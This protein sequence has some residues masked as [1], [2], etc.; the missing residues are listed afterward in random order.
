MVWS[1]PHERWKFAHRTQLW[2][3]GSPIFSIKVFCNKWLNSWLHQSQWTTL[4]KRNN[5]WDGESFFYSNKFEWKIIA[6]EIERVAFPAS[7]SG[8]LSTFSSGIGAFL[9]FEDYIAETVQFRT[10][11]YLE[12]FWHCLHFWLCSGCLYRKT[13]GV[14]YVV[15][16]VDYQLLHTKH[17]LLQKLISMNREN[18]SVWS[19]T[20][21]RWALHVVI[22]SMTLVYISNLNSV[23]R[24]RFCCACS[25]DQ[26][27]P[28]ML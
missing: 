22:S 25:I 18:G 26:V 4:Y 10:W 27:V 6:N 12:H 16:G 7:N 2:D 21:G 15:K 19:F 8:V 11:S 23:F 9:L 28:I 17:F 14:R 13:S 3:N 24:F 20:T 1:G 5:L